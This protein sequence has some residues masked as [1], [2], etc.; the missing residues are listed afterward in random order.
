MNTGRMKKEDKSSVPVTH[1]T[2]E[3]LNSLKI[4]CQYKYRREFTQDDIICFLLD[5]YAAHANADEK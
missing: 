3:Q 2:R 4:D 5:F 1:K